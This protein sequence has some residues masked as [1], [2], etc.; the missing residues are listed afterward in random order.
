MIPPH[1]IRTPRLE[2]VPANSE[3]LVSDY[4]REHDV[5][6][7]LLDAA[8]PAGAWP[9]PLLDSATL[10]E[11]V[12]MQAIGSDPHF[13]SWYWIVAGPEEQPRTLIG[14][15]GTGSSSA[16]PDAVMIGYSV[17]EAFQNRGYATEAV[18]HL[19]PVIFQDPMIQRIVAATFPELKASIRVLEKNGFVPA[20]ATDGGEGMEEGT[21]LYVLEKATA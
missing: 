1:P 11:F 15:G 3:I 13:C 20:G 12:R 6:G 18:R 19:I 9:P 21:V 10:A 17:L 7:R 4:H 5:L 8:I 2:L 14:S 16:G